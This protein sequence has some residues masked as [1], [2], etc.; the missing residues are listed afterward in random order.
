MSIHQ[1]VDFHCTFLFWWHLP[2]TNWTSFDPDLIKMRQ[3]S[4]IIINDQHDEAIKKKIAKCWATFWYFWDI[5]LLLVLIWVREFKGNFMTFHMDINLLQSNDQIFY[6]IQSNSD[7]LWSNRVNLCQSS[8][9][10]H[11]I[12]KTRNFIFLWNFWD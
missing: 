3:W 12:M 4:T 1:N 6:K 11:F 5:T 8:W 2:F 10:I 9:D 7:Q